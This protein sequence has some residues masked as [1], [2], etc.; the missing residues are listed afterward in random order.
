MKNIK[1]IPIVQNHYADIS[2]LIGSDTQLQKELGFKKGSIPTK[3]Q[4]EKDFI[5]WCESH[6]AEMYSIF[7]DD[8]FIGLITISRIDVK[9]KSARLGYWLGSEFR[10]KGYSSIAY[11]KMLDKVP[12]MGIN[13]LNGS[14][15]VS[16]L[17]SRLLWENHG[18][19]EIGKEK[20]N[21]VYELILSYK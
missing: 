9:N 17:P 12:S 2:L 7:K 6:K 13:K 18:A 16:N 14:V 21:I 4:V 11:R 10:Q 8:I 3:L 5:S 15:L 1:L 20:D 19:T